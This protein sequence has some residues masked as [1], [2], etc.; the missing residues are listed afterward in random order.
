VKNDEVQMYYGAADRV[1]G[2]ARAKIVDI[3]SALRH[4]PISDARPENPR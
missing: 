4:L 1:M 3:M 2:L